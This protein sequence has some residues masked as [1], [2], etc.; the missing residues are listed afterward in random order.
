M[1]SDRAYKEYLD[2][3]A[4]RSA[5]EAEHAEEIEAARQEAMKLEES[6]L[7]LPEDAREILKEGQ[8]YILKVREYNDKIPDT[9]VMSDKLYQLENIMKRIFNQVRSVPSSSRE[10]RRFMNYYLPTT[11]K[12][13]GAYIDAQK[14][15]DGENSKKT[16]LEIEKALD[17][18]NSA[19]EQLLDRMFETR[20]WDVSSDISVMQTMMAQDGLA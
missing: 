3:E 4:K 10:L 6:D 7:A 18:I 9:E 17:M 11:D 16:R 20:A 1:L 15:G 5:Y 8:A 14:A 19:F 2:I 13:L 12:L